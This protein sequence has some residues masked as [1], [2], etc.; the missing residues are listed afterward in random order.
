[1]AINGTSA[2]ADVVETTTITR[3]SGPEYAYSIRHHAELVRSGSAWLVNDLSWL[4]ADSM[5]ATLP[6]STETLQRWADPSVKQMIDSKIRHGVPRDKKLVPDSLVGNKQ[7]LTQPSAAAGS[8]YVDTGAIV[9]YAYQW[10]NGTNTFFHSANDDCCDFGSQCLFNG[11]WP[12][13]YNTTD[14]SSDVNWWN[15]ALTDQGHPTYSWSNC[16]DLFEFAC[17]WNSRFFFDFA[18]PV[19][20]GGDIAFWVW[21]GDTTQA[22]P[23]DHV[24]VCTNVDSSG[25]YFC[26]HTPD[27]KDV[28]YS[29]YVS[30]N[31]SL[32]VADA[33]PKTTITG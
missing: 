12:M 19:W 31:P 5:V 2:T 28:S 13:A 10:W 18:T 14:Y 17:D 1:M 23:Y 29:Y 26:Q 27:Q 9:S 21:D 22:D 3:Q 25:T 32:Y 7:L 4:P 30:T 15:D 6:P 16:N 33:H 20:Q 11:G 24:S 8:W